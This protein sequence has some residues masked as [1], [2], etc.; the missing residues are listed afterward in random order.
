MSGTTDDTGPMGRFPAVRAM[1]Q[2]W[3]L[4]VLRGV[5]SMLLGLMVLL[6]PGAGILVFLTFI[7]VWAIF[8]GVA[9]LV[10]AARGEPDPSGRHRS[11]TWLALDGIAS[12]LFGILVLMAPGLSAAVLVICIGAWAAVT[13]VLRLV[14]AFR[15][16]SWTLGLLGLIAVLAGIYMMAAPMI[17]AIVLVWVIGIEALMMGGLFVAFGLRLRKVAND[18]HAADIA[19][20]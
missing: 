1:A 14:L 15:T 19:K 3:W 11:R 17:G 13:G 5:A 12:V 4:F 18:P 20:G 6:S 16:G 9:S 10:H 2:G 7:A 8:D